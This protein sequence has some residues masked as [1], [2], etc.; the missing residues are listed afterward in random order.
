MKRCMIAGRHAAESILMLVALLLLAGVGNPARAADQSPLDFRRLYSYPV[1]QVI[2]GDTIV[3]KYKSR[4]VLM[5]LRGVDARQGD[6]KSFLRGLLEGESVH[7]V[8]PPEGPHNKAGHISAYFF[9]VRDKLFLNEQMLRRGHAVANQDP[10][11]H[12]QLFP[13]FERRAKAE[14]QGIWAD[15]PVRPDIAVAR[16]AEK[17]RATTLEN[18][19]SRHERWRR[20]NEAVVL[21]A[22]ELEAAE[23]RG[24]STVTVNNDRDS[25]I[26]VTFQGPL[27]PVSVVIP[28]GARRSI[29][30]INGYQYQTSFRFEDEP[31]AV[32]QG[33]PVLVDNNNPTITIGTR[34][35]GNFAVRKVL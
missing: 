6:G 29:S 13:V 3:I 30:V 32:Y 18:R 24:I 4:G 20:K 5:Q 27:R 23:E 1:L 19:I 2:D 9:R 8:Y 33:D 11:P 14:K 31:D 26:R 25:K 15:R 7:L 21:E 16:L 17:E 10:G 22:L 12:T 35:D 34:H 28:A